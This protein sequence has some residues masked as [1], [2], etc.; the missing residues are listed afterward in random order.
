MLNWNFK[1]TISYQG[2]TTTQDSRKFEFLVEVYLKK[3]FPLENWRLTK[4]T[5]DGNR[6]LE[7]FC[8]FSGTSMWAEV[9]YTIHT[10]ENISS[11]KYDSTLVS[12]MFEKNLIK[13]FFISSTS[14]G[15]NLIERIKKFYYLSTVK[16]IAFVDGYALAYWL[17][18]NPRPFQVLCKR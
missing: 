11:R 12:S 5:R 6:D 15:N 18:K 7:N 3:R 2:E 1:D 4:A 17:K 16:K 9:K 8:E 14:M 10:D 13:I